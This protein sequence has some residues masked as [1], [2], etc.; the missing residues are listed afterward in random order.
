MSDRYEEAVARVLSDA[1]KA[2][3]SW[4]QRV[5]RVGYN[6]AARYI[7][8]ME[9]D[10]LIS[11]PD[12]VGRR[13]IKDRSPEE[14]AAWA[15]NEGKFDTP[16]SRPAEPSGIVVDLD[17]YRHAL[18]GMPA[19]GEA[20]PI[21][22]IGTEPDEAEPIKPELLMQIIERW[23]ALVVQRSEIAAI[24]GDVRSFSKGCGFDPVALMAVMKARAMDPDKRMQREA[25]IETYRH[26]LGI[27]GPDFAIS[28][29]LRIA[30]PEPVRK[31]SK[32][33]Q[34]VREVLAIQAAQ[35]ASEGGSV[36]E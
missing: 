3:T 13:T 8:R 4:L 31:L 32:R 6:E 27:E 28:L 33:E 7:E 34:S 26:A 2:S 12:H 15:R 5:L 18:R 9:A 24:I 22:A 23:E 1:G 11:K 16:S 17:A 29:P 10:G 35:R 25:T 19:L 21:V 14:V 30:A 36:F 20:T